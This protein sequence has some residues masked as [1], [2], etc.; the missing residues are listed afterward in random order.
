MDDY[1]SSVLS[2]LELPQ[3]VGGKSKRF[4]RRNDPEM[5]DGRVSKGGMWPHQRAFWDLDTFFRVLVGG[6]GSGKTNIGAKWIISLAL[7]NSG[8]PVATVSPSF[9]LAR[10]TIIPTI[11][12]LLQG[13]QSLL[14]GALWW[15]FRRS[16]SCEFEIQHAGRTGLIYIL[17]GDKEESLRGPNLGGALIDEPFIQEESVFSQMVARIRHPAATHKALALTGTPEQLNWGWDLCMGDLKDEY[18]K[19]GL[20]VGVVKASTRQNLAVGADYVNRLLGTFSGKAADAYV[21]GEF[22]N[23]SKGQV[24]YGFNG[25]LNDQESNVRD[26]PMPLNPDGTAAVQLGAGMDFNVNPLAFNV[27]WKQGSH[28]HFFDEYELENADTEYACQ[29]L[30]DNYW[31]LG[32]RDVYPDA[33]GSARRTSAPGG[34][35]DFHYIEAAGFTVQ[36]DHANPKHRDRENSV[37]GKLRPKEGSA[38]LTISPK[39]KKMRKY[40]STYTHELK[41]KQKHM[42]HTL[43][44]LGYPVYYHF[45][46]SSETVSVRKV[47]GF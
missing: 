43:D 25:L 14:G 22:V 15:R 38:T 20:G 16:P 4:W 26:L 18:E 41:L 10:K 31:R 29:V 21:D 34:K 45:P 42:S 28:L 7:Q 47:R 8:V 36:A 17:S 13:K 12:E 24:Y 27:F 1:V 11:I 35:T 32:L 37:N 46:V 5:T 2:H 19:R 44:A 39:C 23:L 30:K 40:L 9:P 6:Y 3:R 33:T